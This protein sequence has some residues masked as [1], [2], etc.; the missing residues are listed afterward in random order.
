M[1][2]LNQVIH[3]DFP[4]F[5]GVGADERSLC[6][7]KIRNPRLMPTSE[8][9]GSTTVP[10]GEDGMPTDTDAATEQTYAIARKLI[11]VGRLWDPTWLPA[12]DDAGEP[13]DDGTEP[14]L[15]KFPLSEVDV[16]KLPLEVFSRIGDEVKKATPH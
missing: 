12:F 10:L 13:I 7:V 8:L 2:Y 11:I 3:L 14:P 1:G 4:D 16:R 6:W 9:A 15:L 5:A